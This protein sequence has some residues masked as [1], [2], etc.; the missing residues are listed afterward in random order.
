MFLWYRFLHCPKIMKTRLSIL[1]CLLVKN[2]NKG[3]VKNTNKG[4]SLL[5]K[6]NNKG[7]GQACGNDIFKIITCQ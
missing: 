4:K 2:T 5:V 3:K 1:S 7:E 6:N